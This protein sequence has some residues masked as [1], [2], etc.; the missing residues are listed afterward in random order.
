M[1]GVIQCIFSDWGKHFGLWY[2]WKY[3]TLEFSNNPVQPKVSHDEYSNRSNQHKGQASTQMWADSKLGS[4]ACVSLLLF[5]LFWQQQKS[6]CFRMQNL[7]KYI[8]I[9][10]KWPP[11]TAMK[12]ENQI[13]EAKVKDR[14]TCH[15]K[16]SLS[17]HYQFLINKR[18]S[19]LDQNMKRHMALVQR[20]PRNLSLWSIHFSLHSTV[21][22]QWCLNSTI[23]KT[24]AFAEDTGQAGQMC[25]PQSACSVTPK[26]PGVQPLPHLPKVTHVSRQSKL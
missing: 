12:K 9:L 16:W 10:R 14:F 22:S 4:V 7:F 8:I 17:I 15:K 23:I 5:Q 11:T 21:F 26:E 1:W 25:I 13:N 19:N 2:L 3:P 6:T 20:R 24:T 18:I